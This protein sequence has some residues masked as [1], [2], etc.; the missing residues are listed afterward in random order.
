VLRTVAHVGTLEAQ[1][2]SKVVA[3]NSAKVEMKAKTKNSLDVIG[4]EEIEITQEEQ[5]LIDIMNKAKDTVKSCG[6]KIPTLVDKIVFS[7]LDRNGD[8]K[9]KP[10]EALSRSNPHASQNEAASMD[11]LSLSDSLS[12]QIMTEDEKALG[13]LQPKDS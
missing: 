5:N 13:A 11:S 6:E 7:N 10:D 2:L 4:T 3:R 8:S 9:D 1:V 12:K